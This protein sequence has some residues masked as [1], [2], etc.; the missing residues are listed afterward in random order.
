VVA[1]QTA[2]D[3][4]GCSTCSCNASPTCTGGLYTFYDVDQC[5]NNGTDAPIPVDDTSCHSLS[6]LLDNGTWSAQ[7]T[8]PVAGGTC[9]P[10]GGDPVG[11]V[12]PTGAMTFCCK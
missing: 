1:Y 11:A 5:Q 9:T 12:N 8:Q 7:A 10:T 2:N 3:D 6:I 4:R